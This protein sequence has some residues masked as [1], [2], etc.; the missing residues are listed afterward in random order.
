MPSWLELDDAAAAMTNVRLACREATI[1]PLVHVAC[2]HYGAAGRSVSVAFVKDASRAPRRPSLTHC[3]SPST[4]PANLWSRFW[5]EASQERRDQR[6][7]ANPSR[8]DG[9][10]RS[11]VFYFCCCVERPVFWLIVG[12]MIDN[13]LLLSACIGKFASY[14]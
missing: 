8:L 6:R 10:R 1:S 2:Y 13:W 14:A 5:T 9:G 12:F 11:L 7:R 3:C 4:L